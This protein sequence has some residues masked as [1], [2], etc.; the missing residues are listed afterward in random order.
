MT[1]TAR[2][3]SWFTCL[4]LCCFGIVDGG[5]LSGFNPRTTI[6]E[7]EEPLHSSPP[8]LVDLGITV[9]WR[10]LHQGLGSDQSVMASLRVCRRVC[11]GLALGCSWISAGA[12]VAVPSSSS[13]ILASAVA[14]ALLP[15]ARRRRRGGALWSRHSTRA[16]ALVEA[17]LFVRCHPLRGRR[18]RRSTPPRV[19]S[20]TI[21]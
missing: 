19:S 8:F 10:E 14:D 4:V 21:G 6:G 12:S 9:G 3:T 2:L 11:G 16:A 20:A 13:R 7:V 1:F 15:R 18:R 5:S 17:V